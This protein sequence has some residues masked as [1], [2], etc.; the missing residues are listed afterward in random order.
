[1]KKA[2]LAVLVAGVMVSTSGLT[3][4][5]SAPLTRE[6]FAV[7][8]V[9]TVDY[10]N[11][12]NLPAKL[13]PDLS[14]TDPAAPAMVTLMNNGILKGYPDGRI[15]PDDP[16]TYLQ[17]MAMIGRALDLP[18]TS[19]APG[20]TV[21]S[22]PSDSW[23]YDIYSWLNQQGLGLPGIS[24]NVPL[25]T[26]QGTALISQ[27][28]GTDQKALNIIEGY[29]AAQ[30][31]VKSVTADISETMSAV[32]SATYAANSAMSIP[33]GVQT[34]AH[35]ALLMPD[36]FEVTATDQIQAPGQAKPTS[37]KMDIYM[38]PEGVYMGS[39]PVL[40]GPERWFKMPEQITEQMLKQLR[41]STVEPLPMAQLSLFHYRLIGQKV[42][43]GVSGDEIAFYGRVNSLT[44]LMPDNQ[45][46][47]V[48]P[49]VTASLGPISFHGFLVIDPATDWLLEA[50][51]DQAIGFPSGPFGLMDQHMT[52]SNFTY[53]QPLTITLPP[54]AA[55][56]TEL[57]LPPNQTPSNP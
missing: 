39:T 47:A 19:P 48:P 5:S 43:G 24:P 42:V 30:N 21:G 26:E 10:Q 52:E 44:S 37:L 36:Q 11:A 9:Q 34:T 50:D 17:A 15:G 4:A 40:G 41:Q 35:L 8:L 38:V 27:V 51:F 55:S 14:A 1:M 28:F 16:V 3:L 20:Q 2:F 23:G 7:Q 49:G 57:P 33:R 32:P 54:A 25:T 45:A 31:S 46:S 12:T 29:K 56:A 22:L 18:E 6:E 53:N 13:P